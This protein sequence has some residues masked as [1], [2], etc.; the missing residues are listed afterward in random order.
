M[1]N[2]KTKK[3]L[4]ENI[5]PIFLFLFFSIYFFVWT[6]FNFSTIVLNTN[7]LETAVKIHNYKPYFS[8]FLNQLIS[9]QKFN[10]YLG[11]VFFP[12][13]TS[14]I[15]F[16]I[17]KKILANNLW[18]LSL[19]FLSIIATENYPFINFLLSFFKDFEIRETVN[20]FE[21]FEIMG[22]PIPSFSTF[23]F[24]LI[25]YLSISNFKFSKLKIY[26]LTFSWLLMLH[27]H[28][29][30]GIIGNIYWII[31][32][33]L[34]FF[35]KRIQLNNKDKFALLFLYILNG[36][37]LIYQ[38]DFTSLELKNSQ[39]ITGY[40]LFF[41]F[42]LPIMLIICCLAIL[43]ID[44][45][46]FYQKFLN[47]YLIMIIELIL[48]FLSIN[49]LG[50]EMQML[51]NRITMFLLHYLY[52]VP[53]IYY[54]SKDEIFYINSTNKR[55]FSGKLVIILFFIFNKYKGIYLISFILLIISYLL[56]SIK[57]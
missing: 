44:F 35:Q 29:L 32:I 57:L 2:F 48:I 18:S 38:L 27:I 51:E 37:F 33:V 17:F 5:Y 54:L 23:F 11:F 31:L 56:L 40:N 16:L 39:S 28:P 55:S 21:N 52:Y 53:I 45:Y 19:T 12:A 43:K 4:S 30:D 26:F 36:F 20:L 22:F 8:F 50:F 42:I 24:S 34:L 46:E 3:F 47:I 9:S 7:D 25:F 6:K 15:L 1:E 41:Y 49:G 13:L 10:F 14:V